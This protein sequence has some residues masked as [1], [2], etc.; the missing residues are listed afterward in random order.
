VEGKAATKISISE[1]HLRLLLEKGEI[2]G[3]RLGREGVVLSLTYKR[4]RKL[5]IV[6]GGTNEKS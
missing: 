4:K 1:R 6:E 3:K 5:G 2:E